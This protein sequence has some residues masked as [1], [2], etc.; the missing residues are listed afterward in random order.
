MRHSLCDGAK[1]FDRREAQ[2][3]LCMLLREVINPWYLTILVGIGALFVV[4]QRYLTTGN[5][6]EQQPG[7]GISA[8]TREDRY[9]IL[10]AKQR[11]IINDVVYH[12]PC[13]IGRAKPMFYEHDAQS[14]AHLYGNHA[15]RNEWCREHNMT[16]TPEQWNKIVCCDETW[17]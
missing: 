9:I 15:R 10:T 12:K 17:L 5:P 6:A 8:T 16:P 7:R 1:S 14:A 2:R 11:S 4:W 13:E 3:D